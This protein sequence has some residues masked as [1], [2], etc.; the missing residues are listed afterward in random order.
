MNSPISGTGS[1][2]ICALMSTP[3]PDLYRDAS[4]IGDPAVA[5][6]MV[7]EGIGLIHDLP[8]A[9]EIIDTTIAVAVSLLESAGGRVKA[10]GY[11]QQGG[12][13]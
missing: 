11:H 9:A 6:T 8:T 12:R 3:R 13:S 4:A 1:R 2:T 7:G 5:A 10:I